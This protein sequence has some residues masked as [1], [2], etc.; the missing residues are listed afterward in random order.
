MIVEH[1]FVTTQGQETA[2]AAAA[3]FL[4]AGGFMREHG[5]SASDQ[6]QSPMLDLRRG[7][8]NAARARSV[9]ELPQRL[10]LQ[11]DRGRITIAASIVA[12][13]VWGGRSR[14][15]VGLD[16]AT[17]GETPQKMRMHQRLLLGIVQGL[18]KLLA[19]NQSDESARVEWLAAE[20][21]IMQAARKRRKQNIIGGIAV[22]VFVCVIVIAIYLAAT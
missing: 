3:A 15:H 13:H 8:K 20:V 11:F 9:S 19:E 6:T 18:E 17:A 5:A 1:E 7:K 21:E 2:L 22:L 4:G 12:N 14:W 16:L 10:I